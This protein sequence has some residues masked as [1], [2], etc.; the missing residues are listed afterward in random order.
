M[1]VSATGV[2]AW[3]LQYTIAGKAWQVV[4]VGPGVFGPGEG[5]GQTG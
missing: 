1:A 5:R 3:G 4:I 2:G